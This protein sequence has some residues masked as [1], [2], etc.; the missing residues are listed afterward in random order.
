MA[1]CDGQVPV[2]MVDCQRIVHLEHLVVVEYGGVYNARVSAHTEA[3][4]R[5]VG[6]TGVEE[7]IPV[8]EVER[9]G[10]LQVLALSGGVAHHASP[11]VAAR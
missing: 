10:I 6:I 1:V 11:N 8:V 3:D 9:D 4:L 7:S 5:S 2:H